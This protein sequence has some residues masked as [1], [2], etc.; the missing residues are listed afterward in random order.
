MSVPNAFMP[1]TRRANAKLP[2]CDGRRGRP[3][4]AKRRR[5]S[6]RPGRRG[7]ARRAGGR[8][9]RRAPRHWPAP[10]ARRPAPPSA[11]RARRGEAVLRDHPRAAG[12]RHLARIGGLVIVGRARQRDEDRRAA[13]RGQL[14]DGRGAG[15]GDDQMRP[16]EPVGHVGDIGGE[17]GRNA[18]LGIALAHRLDILGAALL[19]DLQPAAEMLGSSRP[20][21][22]GT[23]SPRIDAPWLP[24]VTRIR[25]APLVER[26]ER[27]FAQ[28]E[29]PRRAPDCR[30]ASVLSAW[31]AA[32]RSTRSIGG[33]DRVDF[34]GQ[35]AVDPA[36]HGILL[37][38][39]G[40]DLRRA[41]GEQRRQRRIAAE[42]DHR[43]RAMVAYKRARLSPPGHDRSR[44]LDPA[45]RP[46]AQPPGGQDM[47]DHPVEQPGNAGAALVGDQRDVV[48]ARHQLRGERVGRDHMAAGSPGCESEIHP[49][50]QSP[51]HF[52]T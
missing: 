8:P 19:G 32:S 22:S 31:R 18:E 43:L 2:L 12:P 45:E 30:P 16:G 20:R 3:R 44:R 25:K 29:R 26:R 15:A 33:G 21:P 40:R 7:R 39:D 6:V 50:R 47:R 35:Q 14:G 36:E 46:A 41:G 49:G 27:R 52:T 10:A 9:T 17:L 13:R 38:D 34:A 4:P 37:V 28:R 24:P 51:L 5:R 42:A 23:T 11:W 1:G 48:A